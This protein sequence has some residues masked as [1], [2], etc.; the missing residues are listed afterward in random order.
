MFFS[1]I[2]FLNFLIKET[3]RKP[4]VIS[5]IKPDT[6]GQNPCYESYSVF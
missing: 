2:S 6:Y 1:T 4:L 5:E 3:S